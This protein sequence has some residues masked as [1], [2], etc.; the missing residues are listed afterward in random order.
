V[1]RAPWRDAR[2]SDGTKIDDATRGMN[3]VIYIATFN[4]CFA[5][6]SGQGCKFCSFGPLT[7][8]S[9][10]LLS[11][12]GILQAAARS[13]EATTIAI[14]N[15]LRYVLIIGGSAPPEQRDQWTTDLLQ[16]IMDR[17]RDSLDE[18]L[19]SQV[20]FQPSVYPPDDLGEFYRWKDLGINSVEMDCQVMDPAYFKAIC[21]GLRYLRI[22]PAYLLPWHV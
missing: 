5:Y 18:D 1:P 3:G 13:I 2:L 11:M 4:R 15:G 9:G 16:G 14:K 22:R 10:P 21:P 12:S 19:F 8:Q 17:F 6:D 7:A 20:K